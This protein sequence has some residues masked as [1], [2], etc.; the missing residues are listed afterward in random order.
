M[1]FKNSE[2]E[3]I[4]MF[5]ELKNVD[6]LT[7]L[8]TILNR[9][10]IPYEVEEDNDNCKNVVV[11]MTNEKEYILFVSHYDLYPGSTGINDNTAAIAV[12]INVIN[13]LMFSTN[14]IL[15]VKVLFSDKEETGMIGSDS[16]IKKHNDEIIMA[17]VLDIVGY[18][19]RLV[20]GSKDNDLF[21]FLEQYG[22]TNIDRILPSDNLMFN[23]HG[24]PNTLIV[25]THD[26]DIKKSIYEGKTRYTLSHTPKFYESFHN[27]AMDGKIEVINFELVEHLRNSIIKILEM[28]I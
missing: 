27:R 7:A 13:E 4:E 24:I 3:I 15:P 16:Y 19:E 10:E 20:A 23:I 12:M 14:P 22:I 6:R 28:R 21:G 18:G 8:T 1:N 26:A 5:L 11:S 9:F 25:A 2:K 17:I